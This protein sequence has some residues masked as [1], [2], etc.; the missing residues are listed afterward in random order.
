MTNLRQIVPIWP[1]YI[2]TRRVIWNY[3]R[4]VKF[5]KDNAEYRKII[6][7]ALTCCELSLKAG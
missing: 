7:N 1:T 3:Q 4:S 6:V 5:I 2:P